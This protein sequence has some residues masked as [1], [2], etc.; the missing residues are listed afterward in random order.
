[1][2]PHAP[3]TSLA[4]KLLTVGFLDPEVRVNRIKQRAN[5]AKITGAVLYNHMFGRCS[6]ADSSFIK[7]LRQ[8]LTEI[9]IPLLVL[10]GDCLDE[11]TDPCSTLTKISAFTEALNLNKFGNI[12]G[13]IRK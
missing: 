11:T 3:S 12:F 1:L 5:T 6:M 7:Y 13:P 2:D 10:D 4:R 9:G 8:S